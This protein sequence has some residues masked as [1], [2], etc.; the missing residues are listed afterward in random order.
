MAQTIEKPATSITKVF[1]VKGS[2]LTFVPKPFL[3]RL[4]ITGASYLEHTLTSDGAMLT[5]VVKFQT[6]NEAPEL[7]RPEV[8]GPLE[9]ESASVPGPRILR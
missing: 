9:S 5:R 8:V 6:A 4:G 1:F 7:S 2:A 3:E